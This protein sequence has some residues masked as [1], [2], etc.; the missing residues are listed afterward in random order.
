MTAMQRKFLLAILLVS[1]SISPPATSPAAADAC[2]STVL[3]AYGP[4]TA[5][6]TLAWRSWAAQS[7]GTEWSGWNEAKNKARGCH[8]FG[9]PSRRCWARARPC[10]IL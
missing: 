2:K 3:R 7:F 4:S 5:Q 10:R 6:A 9:E 8:A 1:S